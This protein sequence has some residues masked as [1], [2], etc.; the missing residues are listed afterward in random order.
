LGIEELSN[1]MER[2]VTGYGKHEALASKDLWI[3][4]AYFGMPGS[5][6]DI[7]V[8]HRSPVF[9]LFLRGQSTH[10]SVNENTYNMGYYLADGIYP[11][12]TGF[13]KTIRHPM[14]PKT[15]HFASCQEGAGKDIERAFGVLH[16]RW[17]VIRGPTYGWDRDNILETTS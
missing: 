13:V 8:L 6:N 15:R 11:P 12:W 7:K 3:W 17:A 1:F 5:N 2:D 9:S 14:E 10:V 16:A 4:H